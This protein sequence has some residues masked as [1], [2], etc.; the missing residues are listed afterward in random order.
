MFTRLL[1]YL[2]RD[3]SL[4][5]I[6]GAGRTRVLGDG[7]PPAATI[8]VASRRADAAIALNPSLRV[9]EAYMDGTLTIE[10]GTLYDAL[11]VIA[12]NF[13]RVSGHPWL[14]AI[15]RATSRLKQHN[16]R[17]RARRNVAHHYDLSGALYDLFLDRDRQYSCAYFTR[18]DDTL[19]AAQDNKKRHIAAKLLLDRPGLRVLDI[20]SGWGGLGLYLAARTGAD[21]T[22]VTLSTEQHR[23]SEQRAAAA[24]LGA[25]AKFHLR[26]YREQ[27][28]RFDR[29]VSVGMF[30]HVGKRNYREFF[31]RVRDLLADDGVAL[32]H[33]IGYSDAPGSI[34]PFI[35]KYIFPG[36]DLPALSEVFAAVERSGLIVTD[37]EIL[38]LHYAETLRSWRERFMAHR[39]E[40][41]A[42][43]D[44]RFVRMW[45]F[46][47]ALCE[48]GFRYRTNIV[49]QMQLAREHGAVPITR[50][51]M[52]EGERALARSGPEAVSL[53]P[54]AFGDDP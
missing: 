47:L 25:R 52:L 16:P 31:G 26:D 44:A 10:D 7:T 50:D 32:I 2:I 8:R 34:N 3:G 30:E 33:A 45:E 13:D 22:G 38:R 12:R 21:V 46:Y 36:A 17:A 49:F 4:R 48:V 9:G 19:D 6:D 40:A 14:G 37:M 20:G 43:Y 15:E 18:P 5:V 54:A 51:Y 11:A 39:D 24:G 35:R 41:Q 42:L 53:I 27:T 1:A 23:M 28:G 29:I